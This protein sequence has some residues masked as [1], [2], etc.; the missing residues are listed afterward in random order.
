MLVETSVL[1]FPDTETLGDF[2]IENN[3]GQ[4]MVNTLEHSV[5][6][7]LSEQLVMLARIQYDAYAESKLLIS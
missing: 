6:G 1:Y 2:L 4:V 7:E 5:T 3:V